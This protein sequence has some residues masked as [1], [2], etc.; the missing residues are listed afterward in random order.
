MLLPGERLPNTTLPLLPLVV[1][2]PIGSVSAAATFGP[3]YVSVP[4]PFIVIESPTAKP[5]S[6][7]PAAKLPITFPVGSVTVAGAEV[8]KFDPLTWG[9]E[10][11]VTV[12]PG[13][14]VIDG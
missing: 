14:T 12:V 4:P 8:K 10:L 11:T 7:A 3:K 5:V 9:N 6:W 13:E 1:K 2:V